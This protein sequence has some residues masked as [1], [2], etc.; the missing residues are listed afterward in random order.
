MK[1]RRGHAVQIKNLFGI[2][3]AIALHYVSVLRRRAGRRV[4]FHLKVE[5]KRFASII[6]YRKAKN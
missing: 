5:G 1:R 4:R 6:G 3:A 2:G